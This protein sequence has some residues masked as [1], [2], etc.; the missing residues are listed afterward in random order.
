MRVTLSF[1]YIYIYPSINEDAY[2]Y[3]NTHTHKHT[4]NEREKERNTYNTHTHSHC[5]F[6]LPTREFV[7]V[8]NIRLVCLLVLNWLWSQNKHKVYAKLSTA[9]EGRT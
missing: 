9:R 1:I 6:D 7:T 8:E 2:T 3:T 5:K 4:Q